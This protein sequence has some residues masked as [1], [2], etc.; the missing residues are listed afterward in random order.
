M[1]G[2]SRQEALTRFLFLISGGVAAVLLMREGAVEA[3]PAI[4]AGGSI[5]ACLMRSFVND[6]DE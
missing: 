6:E 5:G 1:R 2:L 4:A 3:L